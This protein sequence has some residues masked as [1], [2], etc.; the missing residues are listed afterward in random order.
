MRR[1]A[2]MI[3]CAVIGVFGSG[4]QA[5]DNDVR[6]W[7]HAGPYVGVVAGYSTA[8]LEAEGGVD[9]AAAGA[10]GGFVA[11]YG[12]VNANG[13][14]IGFEADAVLR[15]VKWQ[16]TDGVSTATASNMWTGSARLRVGQVIGPMLLYVTGGAAVTEQKIEI[17]WLGS[18]EE[19]RWGWVGGAGIEAQVT[20]VMTLRLEGLHYQFPDKAFWLAGDSAKIGTGET[21]ARV[22]VTFKLN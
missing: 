5:Q 1:L 18:A 2:A 12:L 14:Y 7:N 16:I 20:R 13:I 8:K 11:G 3:A 21:V 9:W 22:G 4:A 19:I 15:D 17:S 6:A 10:Q